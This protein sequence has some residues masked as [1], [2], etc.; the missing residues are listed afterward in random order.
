[1]IA[2]FS[3]DH[4]QMRYENQE[5]RT[6]HFGLPLRVVSEARFVGGKSSFTSFTYIS[7]RNMPNQEERN[8]RRHFLAEDLTTSWKGLPQD[9]CVGQKNPAE[10]L[11]ISTIS[12]RDLKV[13]QVR[14]ILS[15]IST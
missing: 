12:L 15:H 13:S 14:S 2:G 5:A 1:M 9:G 10:L 3:F 8:I 4:F 6:L 7:Y 11:Q